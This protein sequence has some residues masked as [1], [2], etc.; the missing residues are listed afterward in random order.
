MN[1]Q[2][3][4]TKAVFL[5]ACAG[6]GFFGITM[7]SLGPLLGRIS[8]LGVNA[9]AL[10]STLTAGI[11]IGTLL[12]GPI[13]DKFGYKGLTILSSLLALAGILGLNFFATDLPLQASI[14]SL[15]IGGGVL[16]GLTNALVSDIYDDD[17]RGAR[18][19]LLG[20]CYC[21]GA[22]LWTL[23]NYFIADYHIPLYVMSAVMG[24]FIIYFFFISF[25][26]AKPAEEIG[27]KKSLGLLKYPALLMFGLV[28]FFQSGFEGASGDFTVTFLTKTNGMATDVATLAMTWFTIG[29]LAGRLVLGK[30]M[31]LIKDLGTF[32]LYLS[33]A[34]AGVAVLYFF[35]NPAGSYVAM[36]LIGFGAGA[37]FPVVLGYVGGTFRNLSGT[38]ISI[39]VFI[40]LLGQF[41]L[42]KITGVAFNAGS[43]VTL[44][45]V[46]AGAIIAMMCLIPIAISIGKKT[47]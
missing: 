9:N 47:K 39:A 40:A 3:Y 29:M 10:P 36:T 46:L 25:P 15:G 26:K 33:I 44:P 7:L 2:G 42:K 17:K 19:S 45:V 43:Y 13:V 8:E 11:I 35:G 28:L 18:L 5:A 20:A 31:S 37:T 14:C 4:N 23:L 1:N 12:F 32:Y 6:M 22:L 34:L 16:N 24:C 41:T 38:A 30:I 27:L 21:V